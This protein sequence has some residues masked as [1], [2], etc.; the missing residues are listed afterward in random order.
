MVYKIP[1]S[2]LQHENKEPQYDRV[3]DHKKIKPQKHK[4]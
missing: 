1:Y 4:V 2:K 3:L